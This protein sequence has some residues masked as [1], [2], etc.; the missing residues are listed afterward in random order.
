MNI[1]QFE[2]LLILELQKVMEN[3]IDENQYLGISANARVGA[4]I[5]DWL[6]KKF[7]EYTQDHKYFKNS[8]ASPVGKTKNP[9]DARTLFYINSIQEEIWLD[10]KAIKQQQLDSNP[11][12]GTPNKVIDF[13]LA[14]NFY[15]VYIYVYYTSSDLGL[16]FV[17]INDLYSK[18]YFLKDISSTVRRNPKNQLQVNVSAS[19]EA[20]NRQD[21]ITLL[22]EKLKESHIRQIEISQKKLRSLEAQKQQLL[23]AN[24]RS[25]LELKNKLENLEAFD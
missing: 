9:W 2:N 20:R 5:S 3:I 10:F 18:I 24:E 23:D 7:V 1:E 15:L 14:G 21:F 11:D 6:E 25:E 8:E 22:I 16:Q 13:I 12:I 17:K 19:V 4:E